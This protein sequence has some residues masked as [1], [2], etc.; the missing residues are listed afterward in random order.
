MKKSSVKTER[1]GCLSYLGASLVGA[2]QLGV[3]ISVGLYK[4]LAWLV[5]QIIAL[6]KKLWSIKFTLPLGKEG[7]HTNVIVAL[8]GIIALGFTLCLGCAIVDSTLRAVGVLPTYTPTP[9]PT[10]APTATAT[11]SRTPTATATATR[12]PT[13]SP[14]PTRTP[15]LTPTPKPTLTPSATLTPTVTPTASATPTPQPTATFTP[16]PPTFTPKPPAATATPRPPAA[17][18]TPQPPAATSA[19]VCDCSGN[20]LNCGD[21]Q[22]QRAAQAC[23]NYCI[24][25]GRGDIHDI[26]GNDKD[27]RACESLP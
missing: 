19:P 11:A 25:Q 17:T 4:L 5:A 20:T 1:R 10:V 13:L 18:A 23:Y 2:V 21:F 15:T 16:R 12:T 14:T 7:T 27:G 9:A 26:D 24:A 8:V 22:T 6:G 3:A